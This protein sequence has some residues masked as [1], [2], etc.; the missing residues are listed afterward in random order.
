M[1][2]DYFAWLLLNA[3]ALAI[4]LAVVAGLTASHYRTGSAP[5]IPVRRVVLGY[6]LAVLACA[7]V[8]AAMA[9]ISPEEASL[10]W[11]VPADIYWTAQ[12]TEFLS[13]FA[14]A[15]YAT[16]LGI[17]AIGLP[18][19]MSFGRRRIATIPAV[20]VAAAAISVLVAA[21][22]TVGGEPPFRHFTALAKELVFGHLA[23]AAAFCVGAGVAWWRQGLDART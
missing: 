15:V 10:K 22:L 12:I 20:L 18:I 9:Y 23:I 1:A 21:L 11:K 13:T 17:A 3:V 8:S 19:I 16:L 7:L 4:L 2:A 5:L 6:L 14:F